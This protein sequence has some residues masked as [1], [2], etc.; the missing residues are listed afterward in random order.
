MS[1]PNEQPDVE[2][3]EETNVEEP[4]EDVPV[5]DNSGDG[6][7]PGGGGGSGGGGD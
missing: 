1:D 6:P 3:L 2:A 5:D 4:A 7:D